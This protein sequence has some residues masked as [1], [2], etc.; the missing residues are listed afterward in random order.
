MSMAGVRGNLAP[1]FR[2]DVA[3]AMG[4][5]AILSFMLIPIPPWLLDLGLTVSITL[6]IMVLM[7]TLFIGRALE[8]SSL[9]TAML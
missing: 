9:K 6:A 1:L 7:T 4:M 8:V 5:I 2:G 3:L